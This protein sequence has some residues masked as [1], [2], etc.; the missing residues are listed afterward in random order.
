[1]LNGEFDS[2]K[3]VIVYCDG[4]FKDGIVSSSGI[5]ANF[6]SFI[7]KDSVRSQS[8]LLKSLNDL[9]ILRDLKDLKSLNLL[10]VEEFQFFVDS[11]ILSVHRNVSG[12][13]F[14][15]MYSVYYSYKQGYKSLVVFH[16]YEGLSKWASGEWKSKTEIAKF[17]KDF[18]ENYRKKGFEMFFCK[19]KSHDKDVMNNYVDKLAKDT[20][21][22]RILKGK[23]TKEFISEVV[24]KLD[25]LNYSSI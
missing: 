2:S 23:F 24:S 13:I 14:A 21:R 1:M 6:N 19:V 10:V 12:E 25:S 17:Y 8:E 22:F 18:L 7:T 5:I 4:S 20:L 11:P 15:V 3:V 9:K 16:D